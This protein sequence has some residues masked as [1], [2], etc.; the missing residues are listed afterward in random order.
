VRE[1]GPPPKAAP[2]R[3]PSATQSAI[4]KTRVAAPAEALPGGSTAEVPP[5]EG[6]TVKRIAITRGIEHR[7]PVAADSLSASSEPL[8]AFVEL[9]NDSESDQKVVISFESGGARRGL[10][11][12]S[13]PA[14]N[15]RWRTWGKTTRVRQAGDWVAVVRT[16]GGDELGRKAFTLN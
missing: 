2:A 16:A 14:K 10:I 11:E 15:R 8:Y 1:S 9:R 3:E 4:A 13:V 7:E 5:G 6:L 12:L